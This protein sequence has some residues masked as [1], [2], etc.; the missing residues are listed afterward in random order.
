M[1]ENLFARRTASQTL[2]Q[3]GDE[4]AGTIVG[5][6]VNIANTAKDLLGALWSYGNQQDAQQTRSQE[7]KRDDDAGLG[8]KTGR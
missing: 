5:R 2:R 7:S 6:A 4:Q 3:E 8:K 1:G